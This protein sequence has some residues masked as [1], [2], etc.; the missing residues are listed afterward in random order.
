LAIHGAHEFLK[1]LG[2][3]SNLEKSPGWNLDLETVN[4]PD[5]PAIQIIEG[6]VA[7]LY[8]PEYGMVECC[9]IEEG[10]EMVVRS[11]T[12]SSFGCLG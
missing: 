2:I 6:R 4:I 5:I 10:Y 3:E 11:P 1:A 12:T 8:I 7:D 9:S